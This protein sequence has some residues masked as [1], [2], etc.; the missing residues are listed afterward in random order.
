MTYAMPSLGVG[1][2]MLTLLMRE[3]I[4]G[5]IW[6]FFFGQQLAPVGNPARPENQWLLLAQVKHEV[7]ARLEQS[8]HNAVLINLGKELQPQ[9]VKL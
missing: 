9:Q 1:S 5:D 2:L 7:E 3:R 8:L 6:N 4:G